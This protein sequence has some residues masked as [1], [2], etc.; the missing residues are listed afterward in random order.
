MLDRVCR[1][2]FLIRRSQVRTLPGA[3]VSAVKRTIYTHQQNAISINLAHWLA[4]GKLS[5]TMRRPRKVTIRPRKDRGNKPTVYWRERIGGKLKQ[6][7][8][9]FDTLAEAEDF[10]A[11]KYL[12][13]RSDISPTAIPVAWD[14]L[15]KLFLD[16][17]RANGRSPLT[18]DSYRR[19]LATWESVCGPLDSTQI[20]QLAVDQY[21]SV[22]SQQRR[23]VRRKVNGEWSLV[24]LKRTITPAQLNKELR[25]I[26]S[27]IKW[28]Q[29]R[30]YNKHS[31]TISMVKEP[32]KTPRIL[33]PKEIENLRTQA[34]L[35]PGM[36]CRVAI[37]L[38]T[39]QRCG[40]VERLA[41]SDIDVE[42]NR[43]RFNEKGGRERVLPVS[44]RV[45]QI[46]VDYLATLP[47]GRKWLFHATDPTEKNT[48]AI[49][50]RRRWARMVTLA[51]LPGLTP[52]DL[53]ETCLTMLAKSNVS[54][55]IA[56]RLAGHSSIETTMRHYIN[57]DDEEL[58]RRAVN[59][60]P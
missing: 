58:L 22:R 42:H 16:D 10:A 15:V 5:H 38:G 6:R 40:A 12:E 44:E 14:R 27:L 45:M 18:V 35:H 30:N 46:V 2:G 26:R 48:S 37:L 9:T 39:A 33:T 34:A 53:R 49:W 47:T 13:L 36:K 11:Q 52:H 31:I 4:F 55:V 3:V 50:P 29:A 32:R 51:G 54:A 57:A 17:R 1:N 60:L 24:P 20:N 43:I 25:T 56:Q 7:S 59:E 28:M 19:D 23:L 8:V 41:V 21:K